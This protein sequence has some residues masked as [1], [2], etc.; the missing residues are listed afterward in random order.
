MNEHSLGEF[1]ELVLLLVAAHNQEAYGVM[2]LE[3][4]EQKL[5]RKLNISAVHVA[6]KRMEKKGFVE[7][8]Y[9][10]ITN[11]R[12]GR[13]K[14]YYSITSLGKKVLDQQYQVRTS[15]YKQIPNLSFGQ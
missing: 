3:L 15:I 12:G 4:L 10:G 14:K 8:S 11:E 1:E 5:E 13:R 9:G 7:S 2:I 6:L